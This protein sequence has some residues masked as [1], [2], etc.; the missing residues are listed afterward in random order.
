MH[1]QSS[2]ISQ[3]ESSRLEGEATFVSFLEQN[4]CR[5]GDLSKHLGN[6][7]VCACV[8][9]FLGNFV[10]GMIRVPGEVLEPSR[11]VCVS[12][13]V[14]ALYVYVWY[15]LQRERLGAR[16]VCVRACLVCNVCSVMDFVMKILEIFR[17]VRLLAL[18]VLPVT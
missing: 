4:R 8:Y 6:Q 2:H 15:D 12:V 10:R 11:S 13:C 5:K 7:L 16:Q 1:V 18:F 9:A 14:R 17:S 3:K